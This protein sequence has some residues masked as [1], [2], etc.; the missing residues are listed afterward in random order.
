[1]PLSVVGKTVDPS[2]DRPT[3][4]SQFSITTPHS[5]TAVLLLLLHR[6]I[7]RLESFCFSFLLLLAS[8]IDYFEVILLP[9]DPM[10]ELLPLIPVRSTSLTEIFSHQPVRHFA[11]TQH[12]RLF[13]PPICLPVLLDITEGMLPSGGPAAATVKDRVGLL[14]PRDLAQG[15]PTPVAF[16]VEELVL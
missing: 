11:L 14:L 3:V 1:M 15:G 4:F 16:H 7:R 12:L 2:V 10:T 8:T 6:L 5:S 13:R 9:V